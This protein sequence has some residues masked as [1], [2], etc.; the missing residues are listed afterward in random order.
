MHC[1][2]VQKRRMPADLLSKKFCHFVNEEAQTSA[3]E[4]TDTTSWSWFVG[5]A[6]FAHYMYYYLIHTGRYYDSISVPIN[7]NMSRKS[8]IGRLT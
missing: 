7:L 1:R 6:R 2:A 8:T 3:L 4:T 5:A